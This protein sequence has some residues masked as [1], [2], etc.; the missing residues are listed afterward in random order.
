[1]GLGTDESGDDENPFK[2]SCQIAF[3]LCQSVSPLYLSFSELTEGCH[4]THGFLPLNEQNLLSEK[5]ARVHV[6][7]FV[8]VCMHVCV[9]EHV[10]VDVCIYIYECV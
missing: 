10:C 7:V 1:M 6:C 5:Y 3:V 2:T 8:C 4:Q 9:Y